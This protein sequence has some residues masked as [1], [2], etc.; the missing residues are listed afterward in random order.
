MSLTSFRTILY[1]SILTCVCLTKTYASTITTRV[2]PPEVYPGQPFH[3]VLE[4]D[5]NAPSGLPDF[6][7]LSHDFQINGTAHQASYV[8]S[9]GQSKASSRWTVTLIPKQ[10]GRLTIPSIQIGRAQ[11][12]PTS[13]LVTTRPQAFHASTQRTPDT[14]LFIKNKI[15]TNKPFINQQVRYT[16]KIYHNTSIL[17]AS[18]QPPSLGDALI[19]PL[20]ENHQS[21]VIEHGRPYLIE[22]QNYA[23]FPQKSGTQLIFPPRFQA[24]IYDDVPRRTAAA[25]TSESLEVQAIPQGF[26]SSTWLPAHAI[27]LTEH[28]D[29]PSTSLDEGSTLT[30]TIMIKT[31]GLPAELIP[32]FDFPKNDA[33]NQYPEPPTL[34]TTVQGDSVLGS[35]TYKISYLLNHAGDITI[36]EHTLRW[37]NTHTLK[38]MHAT[39]PAYTLHINAGSSKPP[40]STSKTTPQIIPTPPRTSSTLTKTTPIT[41]ALLKHASIV[42]V[43]LVFAMF[44]L[45]IRKKN[46]RKQAIKKRALKKIKHACKKN[47]PKATQQTVL[48]WAKLTWPNASI[49]NLDGV[50]RL[51]SSTTLKTELKQL[52]HTLYHKPSET[53]AWQ[54]G[55]LWKAI[56]KPYSKKN[57]SKKQ[58]P[59]HLPPINPG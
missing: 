6:N 10:T 59:S 36:P 31:T 39:L 58:P 42:G 37:F 19:L 38:T 48:A 13:I 21:E 52:E 53:H 5:E 17:D 18:Y 32:A 55:A 41:H 27:S 50:A 24:L 57:T 44:Y 12:P 56:K 8:Y 30:R 1:I 25:G 15:S 3:L 16:V 43:L 11:S 26:S 28:Y 29:K 9:N 7:P 40:V 20:G 51:T 35:A 46:Q 4:L 2:D 47:Q 14:A 34:N 23:F 49:L 33:F 45:L 54:G 22:E